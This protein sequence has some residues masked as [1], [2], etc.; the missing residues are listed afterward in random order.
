MIYIGQDGI[1]T[2]SGHSSVIVP[3]VSDMDLENEVLLT[4]PVFR[5]QLDWSYGMEYKIPET[6]IKTMPIGN[7][8]SYHSIP[9]KYRSH[10][11]NICSFELVPDN[12]I[13]VVDFW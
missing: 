8:V 7:T 6:H 1:E 9:S 12:I 3:Q 11:L 5:N 10:V 2:K 4:D 13:H